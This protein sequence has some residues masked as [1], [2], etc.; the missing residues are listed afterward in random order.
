MCVCVLTSALFLASSSTS[1]IS[2]C[3]V[4]RSLLDV[5]LEGGRQGRG[6][7]RGRKGEE[8]QE[9]MVG[10]GRGGHEVR[11]DERGMHTY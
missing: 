9:G 4:C 3:S 2:N 6:K 5:E 8:K 1:S 7:G 11:A 10:T